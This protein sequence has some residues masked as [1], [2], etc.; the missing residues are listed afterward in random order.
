MEVLLIF[1]CNLYIEKT[2]PSTIFIQES[3]QNENTNAKVRCCFII[4]NV[5]ESQYG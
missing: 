5:Q 2:K 3:D 1:F 4:L